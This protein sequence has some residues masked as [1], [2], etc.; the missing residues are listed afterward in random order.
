MRPCVRCFASGVGIDRGTLRYVNVPARVYSSMAQSYQCLFI[1]LEW[2]FMTLFLI[3]Q[4]IIRQS[5]QVAMVTAES[6]HGPHLPQFFIR[7]NVLEAS[8][9]S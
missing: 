7:Q 6:V 1:P 9:I 4:R 8:L 3:R 2:D 5:Y